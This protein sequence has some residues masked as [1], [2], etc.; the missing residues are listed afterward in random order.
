MSEDHRFDLV[1]DKSVLDT[2]ACSDNAPQTIATYF[3]EVIRVLR[4]GG[5]YFCVSYGQPDSRLNFFELAEKQWTLRQVKISCKYAAGN[6]HWA[7]ICKI[8]EAGCQSESHDE[9][10]EKNLQEPMARLMC[11]EKIHSHLAKQRLFKF[12]YTHRRRCVDSGKK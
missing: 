10:V 2:F 8:H 12:V 7:Y 11:L 1:I 5:I 9:A 3:K 4:P 6:A